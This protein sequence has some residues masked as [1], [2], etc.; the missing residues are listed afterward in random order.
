MAG[1][2]Q[3]EKAIQETIAGAYTT[4]NRLGVFVSEDGTTASLTDAEIDTLIQE[5]NQSVD[6]YYAKESP[7]YN[8]YKAANAEYLKVSFRDPQE[9]YNR[10]DGGVKQCEIHSIKMDAGGQS[11]T[12]DADVTKWSLAVSGWQD[13]ESD[14]Q[15]ELFYIV[16]P[17]I[18]K[19][20]VIHQVVKEDGTWKVL[21]TDEYTLV[22]SGYDAGCRDRVLADYDDN[23]A[24]TMKSD[25]GHVYKITDAEAETIL[26]RLAASKDREVKAAAVAVQK[27]LNAYKTEYDSVQAA[28]TAAK[29][30]DVL[31]GNYFALGEA[32]QG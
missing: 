2:G 20:H 27:N 1:S 16:T 13:P 12:V 21:K 29:E 25:D 18:G 15:D 23:E 19:F 8:E 24:V 26:D 32:L 17:S 22:E 5:Y 6:T 28:L 30:L 4:M 9:I 3:D 31:K 10:M 11:A 7:Q 14:T